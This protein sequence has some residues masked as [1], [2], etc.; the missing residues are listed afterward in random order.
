METNLFGVPNFTAS[1]WR[2][3]TRGLGVHGLGV[4]ATR[5]AWV[6]AVSPATGLGLQSVK[7]RAVTCLC[8]RVC[9][10]TGV[11]PNEI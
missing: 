10:K 9:L 1:A 11:A 2:P 7:G 8:I 4:A 5:R 3:Q 6:K